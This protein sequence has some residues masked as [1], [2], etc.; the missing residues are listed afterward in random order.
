MSLS[1]NP[2]Y[3]SPKRGRS[4]T[5][6]GKNWSDRQKIEAVT[7]YLI[8]GSIPMVANTLKIPEHTLWRWKK[9]DWWN[10]CVKEIKQ[11]ENII[12]STKIKN[13][14]EKSWAVVSDR[15]EHG[16]FIYDQKA[17]KL[18]RK[19]V[20]LRDAN[21]V[22]VDSATV[23]AKLQMTENFTVA[24]DQIE[25]KLGKLAKAFQDLAQGVKPKEEMEFVEEVENK[26]EVDEDEYTESNVN[27]EDSLPRLG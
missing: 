7:T 24:A 20:S 21:K 26:E 15:L 12:L 2:N 5:A 14:I 8:L 27:Q 22:A 18:V 25:D 6:I 1:D 10:N 19:P 13:V 17:Q 4:V 16:D 3:V 9:S 23:R 11:E